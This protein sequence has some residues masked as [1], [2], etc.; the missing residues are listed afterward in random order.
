VF[1]LSPIVAIG[2]PANE[3]VIEAFGLS[4]HPFMDIKN[5][6]YTNN[7]ITSVCYIDQYTCQ[8]DKINKE[9][10]QFAMEKI[11][12]A[13]ETRKVKN[14]SSQDQEKLLSNSATADQF[15]EQ[16]EEELNELRHNFICRYNAKLLGIKKVPAIVFNRRYVIYGETDIAKAYQ[17]FQAF[18]KKQNESQE[19][20]DATA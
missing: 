8:Q 17:C 11:K 10:R 16:H 7:I 9:A 5:N 4:S 20:K 3:V 18:L 1:L 19:N 13:K 12:V 15:S 2:Q 14:L 6:N